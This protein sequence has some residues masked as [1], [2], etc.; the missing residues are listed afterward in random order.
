M[1]L[2][3]TVSFSSE[4]SNDGQGQGVGRPSLKTPNEGA[5]AKLR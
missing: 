4:C 5:G 2:E 3:W 1:F